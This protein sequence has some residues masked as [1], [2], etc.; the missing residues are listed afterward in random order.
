MGHPAFLP[1][2]HLERLFGRDMHR[3]SWWVDVPEPANDHDLAPEDLL[4]LALAKK[5]RGR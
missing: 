5:R 1:K 4:F 3:G 2:D